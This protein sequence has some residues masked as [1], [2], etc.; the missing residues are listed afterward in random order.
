MK[1]R[2]RHSPT[3]PAGSGFFAARFAA[4][5]AL[6]GLMGL[7]HAEVTRRPQPPRYRC[8]FTTGGAPA[9]LGSERG[10]NFWCLCAAVHACAGEEETWRGS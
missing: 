6:S 2:G 9:E 10:P 7:S 1:S 8:A 3:T 4:I 5:P